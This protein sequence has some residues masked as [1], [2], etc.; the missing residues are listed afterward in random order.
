MKFSSVALTSLCLQA[1]SGHYI[2]Q[3]LTA[4]GAKGAVWQN[5]RQHT[6]GNSPVEQLSSNDLR[7]NKGAGT[8]GT[9]STVSVAA[10]SSIS[11]HSDTA[12]YHQG[13][14]TFYLTKVDNAATADG[15]TPWFK[16]KEIGPKF[17]GGTWD[18]SNT[19]SVNI[20]SCIPA[21]EYLLRIEQLGLHNPGAA[22]QF[23]ISCA[24]IKVTGGGSKAFSGVSIP[25]HV[26][27]TDPGYTANIYNNFNSYTVPGPAVSTC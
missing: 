5:I 4:N 17:P 25:G 21:G 12:V 20:P 10:G 7:C 16:I 9:T 26:K 1:V 14:V 18:L 8:G 13:P 2:F 11:F 23:Y 22:P 27:A 15:S 19:Y 6:N 3:Q 24:Q